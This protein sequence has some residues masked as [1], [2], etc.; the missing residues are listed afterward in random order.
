MTIRSLLAPLMG[1]AL[2]ACAGRGDAP[3]KP[4]LPEPAVLDGV[5]PKLET[6]PWREGSRPGTTLVFNVKDYGAAGDGTTNDKG[7]LQAALTAGAGAEVFVP[8]GTY[9]VD[10]Q[11]TITASDTRLTLADGATIRALAGFP[12]GTDLLKIGDGSTVYSNI[13]VRGGKI[14]GNNLTGR[15]ILSTGPN[16]NVQIQDMEL[17]GTGRTALDF[18][19]ASAANPAIGC[20]ARGLY[21]HDVNEGIQAVKA[22]DVTF[23]HNRVE[24]MNVNTGVVAQDCLEVSEVTGFLIAKNQCR[25]PGASNSCIDVFENSSDGVVTDNICTGSSDGPSGAIDTDHNVIPCRR[26]TIADNTI[27]GGF[28]SGICTNQGGEIKITGN[29]IRDISPSNTGK[30]MEIKSDDTEIG[31]NQIMR[32]QSYSIH[33]V[34][35]HHNVHI[36]KND[37]DDPVLGAFG[38]ESNINIADA[39]SAGIV[40][41][42]NRM[43]NATGPNHTYN[44][45]N[46]VGAQL[47]VEDNELVGASARPIENE[48]DGGVSARRNRVFL[49]EGELSRSGLPAGIGAPARVRGLRTPLR[50]S[51]R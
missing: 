22:S 49:R 31:N 5:T 45:E 39:R 1:L 26:V 17:T 14:D 47:L 28:E 42:G 23:L 21:V 34:G 9:G 15:A 48:S 19:G 25:N 20:V 10:G 4:R 13:T 16:K 35:A 7:A 50:L 6:Y 18:R 12:A 3:F 46:A 36:V 51:A 29:V 11:L 27:T 32:T 40:I 37:L 38:G 41:R 44:I 24:D 2:V 30:G 8:A 43:S 33:V